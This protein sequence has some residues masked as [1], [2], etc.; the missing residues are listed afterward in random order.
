[1]RAL[2]IVVT[3][4]R[5]NFVAGVAQGVKKMFIQILVT[6]P[7]VKRFHQAILHRFARSET[8]SKDH[9]W[10]GSCGIAIG[11]RVPCARLRPPRLRTVRP[12]SR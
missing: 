2:M 3:A 5:R 12:S 11:A 6:E 10:F 7:S 8:K 4:P 1:M 9:R